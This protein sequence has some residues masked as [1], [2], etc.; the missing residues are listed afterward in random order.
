MSTLAREVAKFRQW[1][2]IRQS[3]DC[4]PGDCSHGA[5]WECDYPD[6]QR[7]YAAVDGFMAEAAQRAITSEE[8][9]LLLYV[10]ARD[11]EDEHVLET[12]GEFPGI[13]A[14][15]AEAAVCFSDVDARWQAAVI[16]GRIGAASTLRRFLEDPAE[17]VRR[18][19]SFALQELESRA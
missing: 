10:L 1:A 6:W 9:E 11:N 12:L 7:L 18:R 19:A 14:Q 17:Y 5:E 8:L 16:A 2:I 15:V 13:A 3:P 4:S